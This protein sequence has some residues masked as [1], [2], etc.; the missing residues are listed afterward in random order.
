MLIQNRDELIYLLTEA[1]EVEHS[2]MC[3]YLYARWSLKDRSEEGLSADELARVDRWRSAISA[4]ALDEMTHLTLVN[5]LL[6]AI[7]AAPHFHRPNFPIAPGY[8]PAQLSIRLAPFD[9][10][11][12]DH[13][14]FV[15]RPEN[16]LDTDSAPYAPQVI[17]Q[18]S[19]DAPQLMPQAQDYAT[20]GELYRSIRS[21]LAQLADRLG[22]R[23]LF[24]GSARA[25]LGPDLAPL[26]GNRL[27]TDLTSAYAALDT[28]VAQGEGSSDD[29][30]HSHY[31]RFLSI[32]DEFREMQAG[33][34]DFQP[35]RPVARNPV[36]RQP[37]EPD[38]KVHLKKPETR[39]LLDLGNAAYALMLRCLDRAYG[40]REDGAAEKRVLVQ[41][42]FELMQ[43][44]R[45]AGEQLTMLPANDDFPGVNAGLTFTMSRTRND[46]G[47]Q[48]AAWL[49]FEERVRALFDAALQISFPRAEVGSALLDRLRG[50][51]EKF[52]QARTSPG[53]APAVQTVRT[54]S[55]VAASPPV[56]P[57]NPGGMPPAEVEIAKGAA[58]TVRFETKRCIHARHCVLGEPTVYRAN[59]PGEWI[60]PDTVSAERVAFTARSCPSGAITYERHDG[61]ANE[62][63]PPVNTARI[64]ENGPLA[65]NAELKIAGSGGALRV[66]RAT[67]CRCGASKNKPFCDGTHNEIAFVASGEPVTIASEPLSVRGGELAVEPL[68]DGPLAVSGPLE[69]C[70]GTG[71]TVLRTE[72]ARLCRCGGS[73]NKPFCDGSHVRIG[74]RTSGVGA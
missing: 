20:V 25:Q 51:A 60:F 43:I 4:I 36:M 22:E 68:P 53:A 18:R 59:T 11:T 72:S 21:G 64:R 26:P 28:I 62:A 27:I 40:E 44:M 71:R 63:A 31:R 48:A 23:D 50:L 65:F 57:A 16:S 3:T 54:G 19:L 66:L 46:F 2:L 12:L 5:N 6:L 33:R 8:F 67:L 7:G 73:N 35:T 10:A 24:C 9:A 38:G 49:Y 74:F 30:E 29:T 47:G 15:E 39:P 56:A 41:A 70:A 58:I 55:P 52:K 37:P 61:G 13:F 42:S 14:V 45:M 69:I 32:R 17:Y 1:A 34:V